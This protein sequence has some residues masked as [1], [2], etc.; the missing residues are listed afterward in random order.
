MTG[1]ICSVKECAFNE[2]HLCCR[3]EINVGK[4]NALKERDTMCQSFNNELN[5][6]ATIFRMPS[7]ATKINCD[8]VNCAHNKER[9]CR[10]ENIEIGD[11]SSDSVVSTKCESFTLGG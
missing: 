4:E 2:K 8:A 10:A 9:I 1:L 6:N 11:A 7:L 5:E 3:Q